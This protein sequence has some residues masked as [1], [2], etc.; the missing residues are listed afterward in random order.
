MQDRMALAVDRAGGLIPYEATGASGALPSG[1]TVAAG[2]SGKEQGENLASVNVS[3][4]HTSLESI[5]QI[6]A[7]SFGGANHASEMD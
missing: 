6:I 5:D 2:M 1:V 7:H 3:H 4:L